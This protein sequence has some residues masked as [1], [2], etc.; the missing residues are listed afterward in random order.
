VDEPDTS[1]PGTR[2]QDRAPRG[3]PLGGGGCTAVFGLPF[4][5][6]GLGAL[7]LGW[8]RTGDDLPGLGMFGT[9]F[10]TAGGWLVWSGVRGAW[11]AWRRRR[12]LARHPHEPWGGDHTWNREGVSAAASGAG[13]LFVLFWLIGVLTLFLRRTMEQAFADPDFRRNWAEDPWS[14]FQSSVPGP[15][16]WLAGF[17]VLFVAITVLSIVMHLL[18]VLRYG[19]GRFLF[20]SFPYFVGEPLT[21]RLRIRAPAGGFDRLTLRLRCIQERAEQGSKKGSNT[22]NVY[23]LWAEKREYERNTLPPGR[24]LDLPV[25]FTPYHDPRLA[26]QLSALPP[27]YWVLEVHGDAPGLD[28][29]AA[30]LMPV[31]TRPGLGA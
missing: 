26:T 10:A 2:V 7:A 27:Q 3:M 28:Y 24:D 14:T 9:L 1:I 13:C 30:F 25:R 15:G 18:H 16:Q 31:Y 5:A 29:N 20:D 6:I 17:I 19:R 23:E 22:I 12:W 21:G 8:N 4:F 11:S